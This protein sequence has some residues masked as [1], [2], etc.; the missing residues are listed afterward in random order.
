MRKYLLLF[1][2]TASINLL[3]QV[4]LTNKLKSYGVTVKE[5]SSSNTP[6]ETNTQQPP[7]ENTTQSATNGEPKLTGN[8]K[9]EY[10]DSNWQ[11]TKDKSQA[12]YYRILEYVTPT[13]VK[14]TIKY[15]YINGIR[16]SEASYISVDP[17][18]IEANDKLEGT[19]YWYDEKGNLKEVAFYEKGNRLNSMSADAYNQSKFKMGDKVDVLVYHVYIKHKFTFTCFLVCKILL[20]EGEKVVFFGGLD[21]LAKAPSF[22]SFSRMLDAMICFFLRSISVFCAILPC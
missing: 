2:F 12:A 8:E 11:P 19:A 21:K 5:K 20:E 17:N 7:S 16:Q 4:N 14:G 6:T 10:Y 18:G 9:M 13:T 3:A 1:L 22:I 15:F